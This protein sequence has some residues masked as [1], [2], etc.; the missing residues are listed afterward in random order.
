MQSHSKIALKIL[1]IISIIIAVLIF[2]S[3]LGLLT[4][5]AEKYKETLASKIENVYPEFY[6]QRENFYDLSGIDQIVEENDKIRNE[7]FDVYYDAVNITSKNEI[8]ENIDAFIDSIVANIENINSYINELI[9]MFET[10]R[11]EEIKQFQ[12]DFKSKSEQI[13]ESM[14]LAIDNIMNVN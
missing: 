10:A 1:I 7:L 6:E 14:E 12:E 3:T 11:D 8:D 13:T 2:I 5:S 9:T 4:N